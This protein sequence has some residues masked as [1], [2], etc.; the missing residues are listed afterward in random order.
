MATRV[1]SRMEAKHNCEN[2]QITQKATLS[3][4]PSGNRTVATIF[5]NGQRVLRRREKGS[6][7]DHIVS[8]VAVN[9]PLRILGFDCFARCCSL[10][11]S[12][13]LMFTNSSDGLITVLPSETTRTKGPWSSWTRMLKTSVCI[14]LRSRRSRVQ[15]PPGPS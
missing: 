1:A 5:G 8:V 2:A 6:G 3:N 7:S 13:R 15:I 4:D 9:K 10:E 11:Q 14:G 12:V